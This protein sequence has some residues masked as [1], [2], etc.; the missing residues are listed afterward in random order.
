VSSPECEKQIFDTR[1]ILEWIS[2]ETA[3]SDLQSSCLHRAS[4]T[5]KILYYPTDAQ[6][7]NSYI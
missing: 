7:Y 1:S 2:R 5:I 4:L 6:I 3:F